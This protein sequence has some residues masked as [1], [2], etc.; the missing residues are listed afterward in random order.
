M[1]GHLKGMSVPSDFIQQFTGA[2]DSE[3]TLPQNT[4]G[5]LVATAGTVNV[6]MHNGTA[7]LL[8]PLVAGY[9]P[10]NFVSI[11]SGGTATNIWAII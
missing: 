3:K 6:T 7:R 11:Q 2:A 1:P 8:V 5:L 4:R 10:G 9:N